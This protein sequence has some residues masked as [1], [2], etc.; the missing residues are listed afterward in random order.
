M[1]YEDNPILVIHPQANNYTSFLNLSSSS[2]LKRSNYNIKT[3]DFKP[4]DIAW[5]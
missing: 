4:L 3:N 1:K 5:V 2:Y